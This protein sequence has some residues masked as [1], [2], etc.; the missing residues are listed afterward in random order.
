MAH[1][2]QVLTIAEVISAWEVAEQTVRYH[3]NRGTFCWRETA[4]GVILID[5]DSVEAF[6]GQDKTN[7]EIEVH[8]ALIRT[9][10]RRKS[11]YHQ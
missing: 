10:R 7:L 8:E 9:R 4:G 11:K 5:R 2:H 6:W 3:I 1:L